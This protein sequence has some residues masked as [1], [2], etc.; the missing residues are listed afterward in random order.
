MHRGL[1]MS[2]KDPTRIWWHNYHQK[3]SN[4]YIRCKGYETIMKIWLDRTSQGDFSYL[5]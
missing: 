1:R 3:D 4:D 5:V 2:L